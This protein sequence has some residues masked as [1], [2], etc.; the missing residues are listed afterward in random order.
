[1]LFYRQHI[2][3]GPSLCLCLRVFLPQ[4]MEG[5]TTKLKKKTKQLKLKNK[6][7][8]LYS[9][10][11][12]SYFSRSAFISFLFCVFDGDEIGGFD[13]FQSLLLLYLFQRP[14]RSRIPHSA[15]AAAILTIIFFLFLGSLNCLLAILLD[16]EELWNLINTL[17]REKEKENGCTRK[18]FS[19]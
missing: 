1:M 10:F 6:I 13:L 3:K 14:S 2:L 8:V 5:R 18:T 16:D 7:V 17:C 9:S 15:A 4:Q 19:D 11:F 12:L